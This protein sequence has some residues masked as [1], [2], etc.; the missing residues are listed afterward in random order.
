M[1][2]LSCLRGKA[3]SGVAPKAAADALADA[4]EG[5]MAKRA[6]IIGKAAAEREAAGEF[7][8]AA[9]AALERETLLR[10]DTVNA[11]IAVAKVAADYKARVAELRAQPGLFGLGNKA[12][13]TLQNR[14]STAL[15]AAM[16]SLLAR[17]PWEIGTGDNVH[18]LAQGL[19][20]QAH[21]LMA[22]QLT[23]LRAGRLGFGD[24]EA[25]ELEVLQALYGKGDVSP[26]AKALADAWSGH[27]APFLFGEHNA[28][29]RGGI[30]ERRDWKLPN[31]AQSREKV[32]AVTREA[33]IERTLPRLDRMQ[34][35]DY[36]T[37]KPLKDGQL[38]ELLGKIHETV[39]SGG[40]V[41]EP[42][43]PGGGR[44]M[45][46]NQRLDHRVLLFKSA[47][48]WVAHASDFG[49]HASVWGAMTGHINSMAN[50]IAMMRVLGP[51]PN[52]TVSFIDALFDR[53]ARQNFSE[54]ADLK[55]AGQAYRLNARASSSAERARKGFHN[56]YGQVSGEASI[57]VHQGLAQTMGDFRAWLVSSQMG[58]AIISSITDFGLVS[59]VA[60]L[61]D[62]P[63]MKVVARY[64]AGMKNNE[65]EIKA[66]Q[67]GFAADS[68]T[69]HFAGVDRVMGEEVRA[70]LAAKVSSAVIRASGLR[71]HSAVLRASFGLEYQAA[72]ANDIGK[73]WAEL[74]Q[75]RR[76]AFARVGL[77]EEHWAV[78]AKAEPWTPRDDAPFLTA[79]DI[80]RTG[81][82]DARRI[83]DRYQR[84][85]DTEMDYAVIESGDPITRA[86]LYGDSQPGTLAG[87]ARRAIGLYKSFP[88]T[89]V[90]L[91]FA[92]AMARGWDGSRMGHAAL[93]FAA[94]S[95]MGVVAMQSKEIAK[96]RDP[97]SL[98]PTTRE[99]GLAWGRAVL[100]GGGLGVFGD[101]LG[102]DKTRFGNSWA[103][104]MAGPQFAAVERVLGTTLLRNVTRAMKGEESH[105]SGDLLYTAAAFVPGS[106]LWFG[107]LAF[108]R[109]IVD[110]AALMIDERAPE[111][112]R[113]MEQEARKS[114]GQ[115]FWWRPGEASPDRGPDLSRMIE[116]AR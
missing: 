14:A 77:G 89:F 25:A 33:Y 48:D 58:S 34:M 23:T 31:P 8:D 4:I 37:G 57:P 65:L 78:I 59:T 36:A 22:E 116:P 13:V 88:I 103:A 71:R 110:Q 17:D 9:G 28:V 24:T 1:S 66:G 38:R 84:M 109:G 3:L 16:R 68:L 96:G 91:H 113:R 98:D 55:D 2:I 92:R 26:E 64:T 18:Y 19:R 107:R 93:T 7:L 5:R 112:F 11:Q 86:F 63:A 40:L 39:S 67:A 70:G 6:E 79:E 87:E 43:A 69:A 104:T 44:A 10:I 52:A 83:A 114:W 54:S 108:Q 51:N 20:G 73:P 75:G 106:S 46:A 95:A 41:D 115:D 35:V 56:L 74:S 27:V 90:N 49:E 97:L 85:I 32:A 81:H 30:A 53:E 62:V 76:D 101:I 42:A 100:Q 50:D 111:R 80:R 102:E 105:L 15:G 12:P 21:R 82:P 94:M 47:D 60:K 45:L 99:G 72:V 61:N 29:S